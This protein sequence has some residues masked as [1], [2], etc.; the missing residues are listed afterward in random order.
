[1]DL[2]GTGLLL[3]SGLIL[4]FF[5]AS[6]LTNVSRETLLCDSKLGYYYLVLAK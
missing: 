1:M 5:H 2:F 3:D 4:V 6:I